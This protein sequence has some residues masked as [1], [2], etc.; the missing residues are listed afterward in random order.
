MG[1]QAVLTDTSVAI[2]LI[3][4]LGDIAMCAKATH[5]LLRA[6]D[7]AR[8]KTLKTLKTLSCSVFF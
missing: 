3:F 2:T 4:A 6:M 7:A 8:E 5:G 1:I